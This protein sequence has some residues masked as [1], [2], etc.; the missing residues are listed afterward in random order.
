MGLNIK[1][2]RRASLEGFATGWDDCFVTVTAMPA[3]QA[4]V[5]QDKIDAC[6]NLKD[7]R[8]LSELLRETCNEVIQ[9]G[10]IINTEK[11]GTAAPYK[12]SKEEVPEV[13]AALGDAWC[14]QVIDVATGA[15]RLKSMAN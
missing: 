2:T 11:D 6:K 12:F 1:A 15:D 4:E 14:I 3:D 8:G 9:S 13:V 5:L 7:A 10:T